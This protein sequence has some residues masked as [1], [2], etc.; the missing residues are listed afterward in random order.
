MLVLTRRHG[1]RIIVTLP[2]GTEIR[3][4]VVRITGSTVRLG[5][6]APDDFKITRSETEQERAR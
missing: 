2:D 5:F 3:L 4:T 6:D 1:E